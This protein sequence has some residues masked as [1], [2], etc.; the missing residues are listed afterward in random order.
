MYTTSDSTRK[1]LS[2]PLFTCPLGFFEKSFLRE[3]NPELDFPL[4]HWQK[5]EISTYCVDSLV[6]NINTFIAHIANNTPIKLWGEETAD[7]MGDTALIPFLVDKKSPVVV[8]C[9]GGG[10]SCV[11]GQVEGVETAQE[12]NKYGYNVALLF[13]R[14]APS[15]FPKPQQDLLRAVRYIRANADKFNLA[16]DKIIAMG[17]SAAGHLCASS[18]ALYKEIPEPVSEK[19]EPLSHVSAKIDA[20]VLN[21][22]VISLNKECHEGS[23]WCLLGENSTEKDWEKYSAQNLVTP[24]FPPTFLWHC[25]AD[26]CV[27]PSNSERMAAALEKS[28]VKHEL[29]LYPNGGHGCGLA[30]YTE[31]EPWFDGAMEF[32]KSVL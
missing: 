22:P 11:C 3:D 14:C 13:Y 15:L 4:S 24:D 1:I 17:Y 19:F 29:H 23:R 31:A 26:T 25:L 6:K 21:Y 12:L 32:V 8:L 18:A 20:L 2:D 9:P 10:Y 30:K 28:G 5:S 7:N 27:P 16:D